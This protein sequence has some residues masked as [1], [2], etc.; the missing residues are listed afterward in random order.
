MN[1]VAFNNGFKQLCT[2]V[3]MQEVSFHFQ[4]AEAKFTEAIEYHPKVGQYYISRARARH[5]LEVSLYY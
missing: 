2:Q 1:L 5:M 3:L 4:E